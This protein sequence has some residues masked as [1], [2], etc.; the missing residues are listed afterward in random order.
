MIEPGAD[1]PTHLLAFLRQH[2]VDAEFVAPGVPMPT[3][4][5]AAAAI[6]VPEEQI[7]KT[8]VFRDDDGQHVVAVANGT[9]RVDR[10]LLARASGLTRPRAASPDDVFALTGYAAGGV[11]PLGLP[12]GTTVIVDRDVADL[13]IAYGGGG[14]EHLLLRLR[15]DDI[16]RLNGAIVA[17]IVAQREDS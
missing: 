9:R 2:Q 7:L 16:I 3:V 13:P 8:L 17:E 1:A 14:Q 6:G 10:Q 12:T 11:S 15:P 4:V 5:S